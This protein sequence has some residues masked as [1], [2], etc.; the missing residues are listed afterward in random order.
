MTKSH[1]ELL[2]DVSAA[3]A[4]R[5]A[6]SEAW[7]RYSGNNP[8]PPALK[9]FKDAG[10]AL[11]RAVEAAKLAGAMPRT[12]TE[13]LHAALDAAFPKARSNEVVEHEGQRYQRKFSPTGDKARP[14]DRF[15]VP[16]K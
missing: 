8:N 10:D 11:R 15:W 12:E 16:A 2:A 5:D 13:L 4:A 9:R 3:T 7:D 6:A 1:E 14:W